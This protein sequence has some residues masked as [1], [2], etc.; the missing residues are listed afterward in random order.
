MYKVSTERYLK[1]L[2]ATVASCKTTKK[3][4]ATNR[5]RYASISNRVPNNADRQV[6]A[7]N[8]GKIK[9]RKE[10]SKQ[11]QQITGNY[12]SILNPNKPDPDN[13]RDQ[14]LAPIIP[15]T[16]PRFPKSITAL[17]SVTKIL[18]D[19]M[20]AE[21]RYFLDKWKEGMIKKLGTEGFSKYQTETFERGRILHSLVANYLLGQ[22]DPTSITADIVANL[23]KS[24][25][26]VVKEHI[27]NV[28]LVEHIVTHADMKYRGVVDC[29]AHYKNELVV[30]DFKTAEKPKNSVSSLYDNPLQV[31]AYC[32]AINNDSSIP[33]H[34][35]DRNICA[36]VV[37]VAYI[38]GSRASVYYLGR[39]K[40]VNEY[41][42]KWTTRL[43]QFTKLVEM[44]Q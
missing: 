44:K 36:G 33:E 2:T 17:P 26:N 15:M 10:D 11:V 9:L 38:D 20:P 37:I 24:I 25:Q 21:N 41:W 6:I 8:R 22:G 5:A 13:V 18:Q 1:L 27:T 28:R 39:D 42:K 7:R 16:A 4:F 43:D 14:M 32:G 19:T 3:R 31:T 40:V 34:V 30:I 23:W 12:I 35:I 29:V